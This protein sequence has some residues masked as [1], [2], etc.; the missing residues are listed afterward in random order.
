MIPISFS[1]L[2]PRYATTPDKI[3]REFLTFAFGRFANASHVCEPE[4]EK[5]REREIDG[6][7]NWETYSQSNIS[8]ETSKRRANW[9][10]RVCVK[11]TEEAHL[12]I[13]IRSI[14]IH[15]SIWTLK[16][17]LLD[18]ESLLIIKTNMETPYVNGYL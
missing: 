5:E 3:A 13:L 15:Y 11:T 4:K 2:Q 1:Q 7:E 12:M 16:A 6:V 17:T 14:S 9:R 10:C 18:P 8:E